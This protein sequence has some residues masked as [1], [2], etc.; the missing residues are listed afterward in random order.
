MLVRAL[1]DTRCR[2]CGAV[3]S[4]NGGEPTTDARLAADVSAALERRFGSYPDPTVP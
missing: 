2:C 4:G 3:A 1:G